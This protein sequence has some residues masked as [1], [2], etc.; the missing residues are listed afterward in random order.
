MD[1]KRPLLQSGDPHGCPGAI[2]VCPG[3]DL[4][5]NSRFVDR[6]GQTAA[7]TSFGKSDG[8]PGVA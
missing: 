5:E 2:D 6:S 1:R 8:L 3:T 7:R 4:P